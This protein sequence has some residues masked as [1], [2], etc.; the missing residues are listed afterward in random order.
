MK[1]IPYIDN[2]FDLGK[3]LKEDGFEIRD[4]GWDSC[5]GSGFSY[6][7]Y[8]K[9]FVEFNQSILIGSKYPT[10]MRVFCYKN[11]SFEHSQETLF[12]GVAPT[13]HHDYDLLM[14]L[15]F[16]SAEFRKRFE[17]KYY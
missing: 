6:E 5:I 14:Q 9:I 13:N 7:D 8:G 16:P 2:S 12:V 3:T 15:L 17:D 1:Q 11:N 4:K 10:D